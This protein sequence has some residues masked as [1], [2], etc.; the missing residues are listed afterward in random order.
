MLENL[1]EIYSFRW[2]WLVFDC[3]RTL[4]HTLVKSEVGMNGDG[5]KVSNINKIN[6]TTRVANENMNENQRK[7][8]WKW[9]L[10]TGMEIE[11]GTLQ[12]NVHICAE[13]QHKDQDKQ[14]YMHEG[15]G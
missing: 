8:K 7:Y 12:Q 9:K 2:S 1:F 15:W 11:M 13:D 14:K 6:E 10:K 3:L 4:D 5:H